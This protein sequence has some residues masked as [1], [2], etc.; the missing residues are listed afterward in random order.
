MRKSS[1][2]WLSPAWGIRNK[3]YNKDNTFISCNIGSQ[4]KPRVKHIPV[5]PLTTFPCFCRHCPYPPTYRVVFSL[6]LK[7]A[8][9]GYV[10][11]LPTQPTKKTKPWNAWQHAACPPTL[12]IQPYP[13]SPLLSPL[14]TC[15]PYVLTISFPP[16]PPSPVTR[17][18]CWTLSYIPIY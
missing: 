1:P 15:S 14:F 16:T 2:W 6:K 11:V 4:I 17:L 18:H 5:A 7:R 10:C 9:K 13:H 12:P 3:K 8:K